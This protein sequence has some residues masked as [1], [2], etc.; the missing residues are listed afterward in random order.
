MLDLN[1]LR[2][3]ALIVEHGG[4]SAAERHTHITKSKLSRRI[5]ELEEQLGARLLQRSTRRLVLTEAGRAFHAHCVAMLEQAEAA[6]Q[7]VEQ[8]HS[9]PTGTVRVTCPTAMAQFYQVTAMVADFMRRY[10]KVRVELDATDRVVNLVEERFDIA[11]RTRGAG[12]ADPALVARRIAS[13]RLILVAAPAYLDVRGMPEDPAQLAQHDTIGS[14]REGAEQGWSL[15]SGDGR[16]LKL[17]HRP[18]MM[19]SDFLVQL[20]SAVGGVGIALLPLRVAWQYLADG[21]LRR[22][23]KDWGT[24]EMPIHLVYASRRQV[25]PSV[26]MLIEHFA[27][28]VP[29]QW[30]EQAA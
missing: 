29:R 28:H 25:L 11:L 24:A 13:S 19:C 8:L 1:D 26:R 22:V 21:T 23:C 14:L 5:G 17:A 3:F 4:F 6:T 12:L 18:R 2:Y 7:A 15:E 9:E 27:E 10:P 16:A 20:Q 30:V